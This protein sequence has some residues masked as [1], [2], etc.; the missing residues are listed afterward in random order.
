MGG[1]GP[2]EAVKV[3]DSLPLPLLLSAAR[4]SVAAQAPAAP[5]VLSGPQRVFPASVGSPAPIVAW[6]QAMQGIVGKS[7]LG[8]GLGAVLPRVSD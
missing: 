5:S 3:S 7:G 4:L 1:A 6:W 2:S 8:P